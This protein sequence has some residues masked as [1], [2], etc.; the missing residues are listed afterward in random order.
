MKTVELA[1]DVEPNRPRI[2]DGVGKD[3]RGRIG[4]SQFAIWILASIF[5][6]LPPSFAFVLAES[7]LIRFLAV[8]VGLAVFYWQLTLAVKRAHDFDKGGATGWLMLVPLIN[9][10]WILRLLS[11]PGTAGPNRFGLPSNEHGRQKGGATATYNQKLHRKQPSVVPTTQEDV[12]VHLKN[13]HDKG[14]LNEAAYLAA[15]LDAVRAH[16]PA[17]PPSSGQP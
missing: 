10:L 8:L 1:P 11:R 15:Q 2:E 13:L 3:F 5:L 16:Y 14:L 12:L 7:F 4:R 17:S 6:S 9:F